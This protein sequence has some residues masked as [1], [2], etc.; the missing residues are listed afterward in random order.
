VSPNSIHYP[1]TFTGSFSVAKRIPFQ[2]VVEVGYVGTF[3]RHLLNV[4]EINTI[5]PGRL[6]SGTIG[7][8]DLSNPLHRA[9][10]AGEVIQSL[11]PFPGYGDCGNNCTG[12][13][14][15]EYTATSNYHSLQ[16]T[17]SRQTGKR[18][19]YFVAY[20][21]GKA[22]GTSFANGEYDRIDPFS[23]RQRS[24]G[25]LSYD[26]T[27]ILNVSYNYQAPDIVKSGWLG[28]AVLNGWQ[29][30]GITT[31]ASGVPLSVG[32]SGDINSDPVENAWL[33]TP[34]HVGFRV[35][36]S[37]AAGSPITPVFTCDPR[38]SGKKVGEKI[39]DVNCIGIPGFG[40]S[41]PYTTPY[42]IRTPSRANFDL[43]IFKNFPL[44]D[45]GKKLQL[46]V[47]AFNI[48]NQAVPG[49][50]GQDIDLALQ[51]T[52]N[53]RVNGVPNGA[54]GTT[55]NVCDPTQGFSLTPQSVQNFGKIVLQRGHRVVE[56]AVKL[57]F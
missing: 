10:L 29:L 45:G 28:K 2:Q 18:F 21:F 12:V 39:L 11:R 57:Y 9:A 30:S 43:S 53:V 41:G 46:R 24:Y 7:N 52:C 19:Q 23:T 34:D 1:R 20:T 36:N 56:L 33:G 35:Q 22:L 4:R 47:G 17:L 15:W 16:A 55:D 50:G 49:V 54:G 3:G 48:F 26:R 8:A 32:F 42:Y 6:F 31:W 37:A 25:V 14:F 5:Q 44:G 27:H 38:R 40:D 13:G 51:T